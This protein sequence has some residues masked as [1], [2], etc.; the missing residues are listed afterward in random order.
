MSSIPGAFF[1][2]SDDELYGD[3]LPGG[4]TP[5]GSD[6]IETDPDDEDFAPESDIHFTDRDDDDDD[7]LDMDDDTGA[8]TTEDRDEAEPTGTL[9]IGVDREDPARSLHLTSTCAH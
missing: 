3:G 7:D 1:S 8:E 9:S 4:L 2:D 5:T 6:L